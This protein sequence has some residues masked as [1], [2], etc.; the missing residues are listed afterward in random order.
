MYCDTAMRLA[1]LRLVT[2]GVAAIVPCCVITRSRTVAVLLPALYWLPTGLTPWQP[3]QVLVQTLWP[4]EWAA[5]VVGARVAAARPP[6]TTRK[7]RANDLVILPPRQDLIYARSI[8]VTF[9]RCHA[10]KPH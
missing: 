5:N 3:E 8:P 4:V 9:G 7:R 10:H 6:A 2:E 1:A